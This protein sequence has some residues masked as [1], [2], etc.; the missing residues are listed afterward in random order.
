MTA[1]YGLC[2]TKELCI[3]MCYVVCVSAPLYVRTS[4][5]DTV[6]HFLSENF[7]DIAHCHKSPYCRWFYLICCTSGL[8]GLNHPSQEF[9]QVLVFALMQISSRTS[10]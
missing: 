2:V 7:I 8:S 5:V 1:R 9:Y 4:T 3:C 6:G 10:G